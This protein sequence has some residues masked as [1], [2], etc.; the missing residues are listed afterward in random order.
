MACSS[1]GVVTTLLLSVFMRK[2]RRGFEG[3]LVQQEFTLDKFLHV[4]NVKYCWTRNLFK[5][6]NNNLLWTSILSNANCCWTKSVQRKKVLDKRSS[7]KTLSIFTQHFLSNT[8]LCWTKTCPTKILVGQK[9]VS[10][11][12]KNLRWTKTFP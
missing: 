8:N 10:L 3:I 5:L 9:N 12:N 7:V 2:R 1:F 4:S 6:S 11:Y